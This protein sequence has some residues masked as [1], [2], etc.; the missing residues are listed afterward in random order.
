MSDNGGLSHHARGGQPN[1]HNL[2]LKSGKGSVYEGGIREPMIVKWQGLVKPSAV[3]KQYVSIEDFYPSILEMA[4]LKNYKTVQKIDG[5]SFVPI[6]KNADY[7]D[8]N[9]EL[10]WHFPNKW[11]SEDGPGINYF[12]AIRQGDWKLVYSMRSEK[13]ELYNLKEDIGEVNDLAT[14]YPEKMKQLA[15]LLTNKLKDAKA[16]MPTFKATGKLV[17]WPNE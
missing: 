2:P 9:R 16:P 12:S 11:T 6:L 10:I 5:K 17:P 15:D 14:K 3:A 8:N 7:V 4:G 13:K 1:T